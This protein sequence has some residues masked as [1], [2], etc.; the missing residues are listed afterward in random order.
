VFLCLHQPIGFQGNVLNQNGRVF[1][2]L[3]EAGS[4]WADREDIVYF[5]G[6]RSHREKGKRDA[7]YGYAEHNCDVCHSNRNTTEVSFWQE[8]SRFKF[9]F[10]PFGYGWDCHRTYELIALGVVPILPCWIGAYAYRQY[11]VVVIHDLDE[12]NSSNLALWT[13]QLAPLMRP[14]KRGDILRKLAPQYWSD[15]LNAEYQDMTMD[16]NTS[17]EVLQG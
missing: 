14:E 4:V 10:S 8:V 3:V 1:D 17:H 12:I 2:G 13:K 5:G 11:P 6:F 15:M 7:A 9:A 16:E